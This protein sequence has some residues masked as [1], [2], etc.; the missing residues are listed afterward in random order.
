MYYILLALKYFVFTYSPVLELR[1]KLLS[2]IFTLVPFCEGLSSGDLM[3]EL[4]IDINNPWKIH[5]INIQKVK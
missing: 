4:T 5:H 2:I 1:I 3:K